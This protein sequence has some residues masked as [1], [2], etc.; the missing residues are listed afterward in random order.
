MLSMCLALVLTAAQAARRAA[1]TAAEIAAAQALL[2]YLAETAPARL[3]QVSGRSDHLAWS[4]E[5]SAISDQ[6]LRP[7]LCRVVVR[8]R[9]EKSRRRYELSTERPCPE[10]A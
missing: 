6:R 2:R 3:D 8:L 10:A 7:R 1:E 5:V 9:G 4:R